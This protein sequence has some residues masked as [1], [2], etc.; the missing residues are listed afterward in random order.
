[1]PIEYQTR[2]IAPPDRPAY[3]AGW[4]ALMVGGAVFLAGGLGA[5]AL[6]GIPGTTGGNSPNQQMTSGAPQPTNESTFGNSGTRETTGY[7]APAEARPPR[8]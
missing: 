5:I 3:A 6:Y 2:E 7:G 1:M 4:I 8:S